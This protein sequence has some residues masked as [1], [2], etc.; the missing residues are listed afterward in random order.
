[1]RRVMFGRRILILVLVL[2]GLT[3]LAT[4]VAPPPETARRTT[5]VTPTPSATDTPAPLADAARPAVVTR[6]V[7]A[8]T[9]AAPVRI[10]VPADGTLELTVTV[11]APDTV[12]LGDLDL[13]PATPESP[14]Q[15]RLFAAPPGD[16]PLR[17]LEAQRDLGVVRV[18][19]ASAAR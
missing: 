10:D 9:E 17:L 13:E 1:M 18:S 14:A 5:G 8:T 19:A 15:L 3:A 12:V 16:Y 4:T 2:M 6:A 7:D 11:S